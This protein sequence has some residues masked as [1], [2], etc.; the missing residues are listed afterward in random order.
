MEDYN[1][2]C[3]RNVDG[4]DKKGHNRKSKKKKRVAIIG[5]GISGIQ[6]MKCCIAEGL[7]PYCFEA[8]DSVGGLWLYKE[9]VN[10]WS[11]YR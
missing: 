1:E 10:S 11:V 9:K 5:A 8:T 6:A 3:P 4:T 7:V 2:E